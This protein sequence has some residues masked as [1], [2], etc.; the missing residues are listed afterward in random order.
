MTKHGSFG[1]VAWDGTPLLLKDNQE[2]MEI[3]FSVALLS[4]VTRGE[5]VLHDLC[6]EAYEKIGYG[7]GEDTF[8]DFNSVE[9]A[10]THGVTLLHILSAEL[11]GL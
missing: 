7:S 4:Y 10:N 6:I 8:R 11:Q 1:G 5:I 3:A 9:G 2:S